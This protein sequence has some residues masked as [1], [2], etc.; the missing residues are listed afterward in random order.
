MALFTAVSIPAVIP[1]LQILFDQAPKVTTKPT[2][3]STADLIDYAKYWFSHSMEVNGK[4][5]TLVYM[6]A[7]I[8]ALYFLINFFRYLSLFVMAPVRNGIVKDLRQQLFSKMLTL[9]LSYFS[10]E[11]KY[12]VRL[13]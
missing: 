11:R 3:Q 12:I 2:V 1:F 5:T 10:E 6:C 13:R 4:E 9:P 8:V 7:V